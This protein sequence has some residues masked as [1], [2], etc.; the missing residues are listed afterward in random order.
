VTRISGFF[1]LTLML[2]VHE[3]AKADVVDSTQFDG[4]LYVLGAVDDSNG[5]G[6]IE[7]FGRERIGGKLD[8]IG[9]FL[10]GGLNG[11]LAGGQQD[12]LASDGRHLY[13]VNAGSNTLSVLSI[14]SNGR[15]SLIQ[16]VSS[17]GLRPASIAIRGSRLYVNN[18]GHLPDDAPQPATVVGFSIGADGSLSRLPCEPVVST[19]GELGNIVS[20][21]A[22][23]SAGTAL[24]TVG[25]LS[26]N[27]DSYHIDAQGC[28]QKRQTLA[29]GG[30]PFAVVFRPS[31]DNALVTTAEP[32]FGAEVSPGIFSF[33]VGS[34]GSFKK[35]NSFIDPDKTDQGLRDPC[36]TAL[37][38]DGAHV[39]V[40]SFIPR[41]INVFGVDPSGKL[42]RLS[43]HRPT[44]SVP[45]PLNP[46]STTVVG[47]FD[48]ATDGAKTHL[49]QIRGVS[50]TDGNPRVPRSIHTF[51]VTGNFNVDAGLHEVDVT[52]LPVDT[53]TRGIPGLVFIDRTVN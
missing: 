36:W 9:R 29:I 14:A 49:Y 22:I 42:T 33:K 51:E 10:T 6:E 24:M 35:L 32:E 39:W 26:N 48:L 11:E 18:A 25:L 13:A 15:L 38:K 20:D 30:G 16:Q 4:F 44:D 45:D 46:G 21:V 12:G 8:P 34:D 40:G 47:A 17:G 37:A 3:G 50:T 19:P 43:E 41:S 7:A 53:E 2:F 52:P 28:L 23:N 5:P 31:T 1:L 27:I